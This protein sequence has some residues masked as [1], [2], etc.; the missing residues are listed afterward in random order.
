MKH[1]AVTLLRNDYH[2]EKKCLEFDRSCRRVKLLQH[3]G[4]RPPK[5]SLKHCF[6]LVSLW[7]FREWRGFHADPP[8]LLRRHML[9]ASSAAHLIW[10]EGGA[11]GGF[12]GW[13]GAGGGGTD[14]SHQGLYRII[15]V[16]LCSVQC[17][18]LILISPACRCR[19]ACLCS[20]ILNFFFFFFLR[21]EKNTKHARKFCKAKG[22]F[23]QHV[24]KTN[25]ETHDHDNFVSREKRW[26]WWCHILYIFLSSSGCEM[27]LPAGEA[28]FTLRGV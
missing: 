19:E 25:T 8:V 28:G 2:G 18:L 6:K 4:P 27:D 9:P 23:V 10:R 15:F 16:C 20:R 22:L 26:P 5:T 12:R 7:V 11:D 13:V 17:L 24:K 1:C 3:D 14:T 21:R